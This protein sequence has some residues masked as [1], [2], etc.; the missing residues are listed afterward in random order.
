M[1]GGDDVVGTKAKTE[2]L[3][4][5]VPFAVKHFGILIASIIV[6]PLF[7]FVFIWFCYKML[8]RVIKIAFF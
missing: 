1:K 2:E 8:K 3:A 5:F 7:P 4:D 6:F